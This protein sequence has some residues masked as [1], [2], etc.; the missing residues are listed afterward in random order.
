M[1]NNLRLRTQVG[2]LQSLSFI[3]GNNRRYSGNNITTT[4]NKCS[5][6]ILCYLRTICVP[7]LSPLGKESG[8]YNGHVVLTAGQNDLLS[9]FLKVS[10]VVPTLSSTPSLL[11]YCSQQ[12]L[13]LQF[14]YY[15]L[16]SFLIGTV[17]K[18]CSTYYLCYFI[19]YCN[20]RACVL[21]LCTSFI[22]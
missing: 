6:H 16:Q 1:N 18:D 7:I 14:E 5:L 10:R 9:V 8:V 22:F 11:P 20:F 17:I 21:L 2:L 13:H 15:V 12:H 19:F 3:R 4:V